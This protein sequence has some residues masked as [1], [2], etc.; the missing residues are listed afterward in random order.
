[1]EWTQGRARRR[2]SRPRCKALAEGKITEALNQKDKHD[3]H[4]GRRAR[5]DA[6]SPTQLAAEFPDNA[7]G[8]Q[9]ASLGDVEYNA[10]PRAGARHRATASTAASRTKSAR[11]RSTPACCRART[12]RRSSRAAR[13]R[14]SSPRRSARRTTCS[15]STRST[16]RR[17]RPSRSCCTTTSRRSPRA[18][19]GRCAAPSRREIGHGN[20]AERALQGVLPA[21]E[22]FPYTIRIVSDVLESNG[23]SS[24]ASVCGGSLALFD[25]GVPM[26]AAVAGVA[27]GLIK[28]GKKYAILTDILGTE[29]HLGDMDFKVAGTKNGHHVDPD[30]H[31]DRGPRSQDHEGGARAGEGRPPAH[32]RRDGQ[33]ARRRRAPT[34]RRTR[35][36]S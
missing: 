23:S 26:R 25:A 7:Q 10:A 17:R 15:A 1:M 2:R 18:K 4:R 16:S 30:G 11:S 8:H 33:G 21:F 28:E 12:A 27:M 29:D 31:Q 5:E 3:A 36:A 13:R 19:C 14:R 6:K 22:E 34:C 35:R 32:P 24:M 9:G 20:L